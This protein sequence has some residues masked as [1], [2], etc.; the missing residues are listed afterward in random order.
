MLL[1]TNIMV[2]DNGSILGG[3]TNVAIV[4]L[5]TIVI[6]VAGIINLIYLLM[7]QFMEFMEL[8]IYHIK[9]D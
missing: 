5:D 2:K 8:Y 1:D 7:T 3:G 9:P 6:P 4:R